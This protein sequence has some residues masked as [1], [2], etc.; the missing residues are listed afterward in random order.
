MKIAIVYSSLTGNTKKLAEGV[1]NKIPS[2]FEKSIFNENDEYDLSEYDIVIPAFWI[3]RSFPNKSMKNFISKLKNK[4][5]FFMGTMGFFPDSK[6]GRDCAENTLSIID[7]S[8]EVL[9]YFICNGKVDM[10]L[11]KNISKMKAESVGEKAFKAHMLDEKNILRYKILGEHTTD[12][13]VDYAS[14]RLNERLLMEDEIAK[15]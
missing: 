15:L 6:H 5:I 13:D 11:L 12:L 10:N 8:C 2:N 1:F 9:G 14:A 3:D 4:K 7:E